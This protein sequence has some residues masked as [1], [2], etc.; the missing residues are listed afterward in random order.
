MDVGVATLWLP[1]LRLSGRAGLDSL[2]EEGE[3]GMAGHQRP[4]RCSVLMVATSDEV[5]AMARKPHIPC[6]ESCGP[7][8][9]CLC[10][11]S[12]WGGGQS[13]LKEECASVCVCVRARVRVCV[14]VNVSFVFCACV[15]C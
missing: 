11:N 15:V 13:S 8:T 6:P 14:G 2:S 1:L 7:A 10:E 3:A 4:C 5:S 12:G 9:G